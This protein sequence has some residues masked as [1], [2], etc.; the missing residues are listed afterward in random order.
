MRTVFVIMPRLKIFR[1]TLFFK[2]QWRGFP[3]FM[4][5]CPPP[6]R[7]SGDSGHPHHRCSLPGKGRMQWKE[8]ASEWWNLPAQRTSAPFLGL[9]RLSRD[10]SKTIF[11]N[12]KTTGHLCKVTRKVRKHQQNRRVEPGKQVEHLRSSVEAL[13][14]QVQPVVS[15]NSGQN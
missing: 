4:V 8:G 7:S 6:F 9:Q 14:L 1:K 15:R 5:L 10:A 13:I 2:G 12:L 11:N 3:S